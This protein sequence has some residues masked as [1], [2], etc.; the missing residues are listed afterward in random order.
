MKLPILLLVLLA[1]TPFAS[2]IDTYI[3]AGQ[4]NGWRLSSLA[5][6]NEAIEGPSIH[7]FG[8]QCVSEPEESEMITLTSLS[9]T[10]K[11]TGLAQ[12]LLNQAN[13]EDIVFIQYCRCGAPV[14]GESEK[15]WWP[16]SDPAN[17]ETFEGGLFAKFETYLTRARAQVQ[18]EIGEDLK[19]K[20]IFW[21]Q[22]ES[23][24]STDKILFE[25][26]LAKVFGRFR[27]IT[28]TPELPIVAGHIR[29]LSEGRAGVNAAISRIAA[30]DPNITAIPLSNL[31]FEPDKEG[32]PDVHIATAGCHELG[33]QMAGAMEKLQSR[34][35]P[36][37]IY[38]PSRGSN[39][40][41]V[42]KATPNEE[43]LEL[44]KVEQ[45]D[46]GFSP[47]TIAAHPF[48]PQFYVSTNR[49]GANGAPVDGAVV[50][51]G[52]DGFEIFPF[53]AAH[54]YSYLS[55]DHRNRFLLGCNYGDGFIDVYEL[56]NDG[57]PSA[58]VSSL[59]EGRKAAHAVLP[60]PDNRFVYIPY[61]KE[62]NALFQ[63]H[64]DPDT[65]ALS[66][67]ETLDA[68]PPEGTGPRHLAYHPTLPMLYFSN[69]Q[70]LGVS[71]YQKADDGQLSLQ[72]VCDITGFERPEDGISSSD[73]LITPD[74]RYL[75]AGIR[76]N[77]HDLDFISRYEVLEN[78]EVKH[79]GLT[80]ADAVPWG[81]T[82]SPDASFLFATGFKSG[83][84]MA[85]RV[86]EDGDLERVATMDWDENISDIVAW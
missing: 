15:S 40:L 85:F 39:S 64:F 25:E 20:G 5:P 60:S 4:S 46:L 56:D 35:G 68:L 72:Q 42:L 23:D 54:G 65:G 67:L 37:H 52:D 53:E 7:Y 63:Y 84:L 31:T 44:S 17:G 78:G 75:F 83:T 12:A 62:H 38:A 24:E 33:Q 47:A 73:I 36:F 10:H 30:N 11:G 29:E 2:A 66:A 1:L 57:I 76:G 82:L 49:N 21:H 9:P 22:G 43:G 6:G 3:V 74:G 34:G 71:V 80:K 19:F 59:N 28:D 79:L 70:H 61:V 41:W 13:G 81:L 16:G 51:H 27:D 26:T 14:T 77:K 86:K 48:K 8:M 58:L 50:R 32:K 18:S 69:E 45:L 55:L